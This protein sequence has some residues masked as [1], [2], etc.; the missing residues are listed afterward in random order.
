M[1]VCC[2]H[3]YECPKCL[4]SIEIKSINNVLHGNL[5]TNTML[6]LLL[7]VKAK[8]SFLVMSAY[9]YEF[10]CIYFY[11]TIAANNLEVE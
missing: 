1:P 3:N 10:T 9:S 7:F 2:S 4:F 5:K 11:N 6:L 8:D